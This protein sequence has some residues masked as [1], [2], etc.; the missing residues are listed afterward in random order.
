MPQQPSKLNPETPGDESEFV[1]SLETV[2]RSLVAVKERYTQIQV[3]RQRQAE[4]GNLRE[5]VRKSVRQN[6]LPELKK[7]LREIEQELEAI[8]LN[9]E[10]SLFSWGSI[11]QPFWQAVRF[12]GLGILLGW[13]LKSYAG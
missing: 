7:E 2:E 11:K 12:G 9:L 3:D 10:S 5:D 8:E 13:V 6:P 1:Q 4:L